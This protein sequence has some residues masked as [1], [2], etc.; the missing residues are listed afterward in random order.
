MGQADYLIQTT[1]R[2]YPEV[3]KAPH[4]I[5]Y[6][7]PSIRYRLWTARL[8]RRFLPTHHSYGARLTMA[9]AIRSLAGV[10]AK[11]S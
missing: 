3:Y 11:L 10:Q 2:S 4:R 9:E 5:D 7:P 6:A 8:S 1:R